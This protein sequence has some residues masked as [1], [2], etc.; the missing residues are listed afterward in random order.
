MDR[1]SCGVRRSLTPERVNDLVT[2]NNPA[3]LNGQCCQHGSLLRR[4]QFNFL[5]FQPCPYRTKDLNTEPA[6]KCFR[7]GGLQQARVPRAVTRLTRKSDLSSSLS[8][9]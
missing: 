8:L 1:V 2:R 9:R 5:V 4:P 6:R 7:Y 3:C